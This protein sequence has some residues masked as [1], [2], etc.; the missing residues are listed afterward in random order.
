MGVQCEL[1]VPCKPGTKKV[2]PSSDGLQPYLSCFCVVFKITF[3]PVVLYENPVQTFGR[4][5]C[6]GLRCRNSKWEKQRGGKSSSLSC[7]LPLPPIPSRAQKV[8]A[9]DDDDS[10]ESPL[11]QADVETSHMREF[12]KAAV[13]PGVRWWRKLPVGAGFFRQA[14][15]RVVLVPWTGWADVAWLVHN[16]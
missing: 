15:A 16:P 4:H 13:L 3:L 8:S 11:L 9:I 7:F 1:G 2:A 14:R 10:S 6:S 5:A 12:L